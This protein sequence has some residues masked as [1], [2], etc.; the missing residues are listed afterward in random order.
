MSAKYRLDIL[1]D[2]SV[3][4]EIQEWYRKYDSTYEGDCGIDLVCPEEVNIE[5][6]AN[7]VAVINYKIKA[8]MTNIATNEKVSYYLY[9]RSSISNF[10]LQ[11]ANSVGII[12]SG[13]RGFLMAKVRYLPI[14]YADM[15]SPYS[16]YTINKY[17]RLF[18]ICAPDLGKIV[19][20]IVEELDATQR[21]DRGFGSSGTTV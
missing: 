1:I 18:Q 17:L 8:S 20:N 6:V 13:Y 15:S 3:S 19:V 11:M 9:P 2:K 12:D 7:S 4:N 5:G 16:S 21:E 14:V 10:P